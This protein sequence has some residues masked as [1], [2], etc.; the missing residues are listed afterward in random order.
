MIERQLECMELSNAQDAALRH[1]KERA[2]LRQAQARERL[3]TI[4]SNARCTNEMFEKAMRNIREHARVA[5]HFHPDRFGLN[6]RTVAESGHFCPSQIGRA[7][8]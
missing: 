4:L 5:L 7:H 6:S 1:V 2:R 3:T 8:V